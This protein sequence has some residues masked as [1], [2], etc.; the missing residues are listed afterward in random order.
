M[1]FGKMN[2]FANIVKI[3]Q[4]KGSEG[5]THSEDE[6]LASV[7]VYREGRHGSQRW[8]NLSAFIEATDL[9]SFRCIPGLTVTMA[10]VEAI[11]K[12]IDGIITAVLNAIP[13]IIQAGIDLLI[14]LI[15]ALPQII[16][17]IVQAIPQIISGIVN[18]LVG[19]I[20]KIIMAGVQL[21]VALIE[22]LPT[23]IVEIVKAV[24]Q[25]IAGIVKAFGSLMY[26]IVEIGGNIVKGLWSGITQLASWL[27]DKVSGWIS[28]IWDGICDFFG[29]HSP[30][31]EMAWV[32]EMLVKGLS[33]SIEDNG[34]EAVKAAEGMAEDINGVMGDLAH[35]MQTALPTDFDVSGSFRSAV[36][37]V[38]GK[39]AS[40]F[41]I[42]LNIA[43][44]NNY[45]SEDI[46]QLTNEVMETANQFAQR[47]GVV[48][49]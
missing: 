9:F 35:D 46:R 7:R 25:I 20:D 12:I 41:T 4:V 24:P 44:F 8:A 11:P 21:F 19:N 37:G 30:S 13:Q 36:D 1:S 28:S 39:A 31:K 29:I 17:T 45:S 32:G 49:A 40:A 33:G 16:T 43:T 5:F 23:I 14:S 34:D 2:G 26:K 22:N 6:V 18:A 15:Q 42:A 47:K 10:I 38:T 48:F 3:R 27:W